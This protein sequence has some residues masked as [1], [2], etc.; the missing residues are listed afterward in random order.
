MSIITGVKLLLESP[1]GAFSLLCLLSLCVLSWHLGIAWA[2]AA[3]AAWAAFF[4]IVP[5]AL[6]YFEHRET[7]A[8][9]NLPPPPPVAPSFPSRGTP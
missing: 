6:G 7:L 4:G 9:M 1:S 2:T 3:A 5:S 8:Q